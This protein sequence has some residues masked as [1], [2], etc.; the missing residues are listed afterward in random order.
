M[1]RAAILFA[2]GL[3]GTFFPFYTVVLERVRIPGVLQRIAVVYLC[4]AFA[5]LYLKPKARAG[6]A[7]ALLAVYWALMKL[8]PVPDFGAGDLSPQGNF[9][10]W[11]DHQLL[12]AHTWRYAPGPGDPEGILSTLPAIVSALFGIFCGDLLRGALP[13]GAKLRRMLG[14][15][16][17]GAAAGLL[18]AP[19]FPLNKNLWSPTYVLFTTGLALFCLAATFWLVDLRG[20]AWASRLAGRGP[21]RSSAATRSSP[22]SAAA[23]WPRRCWWSSAGRRRARRSP[24]R[25]GSTSTA[26]PPSCPTT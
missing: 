23:S 5:Y 8:A 22:S 16:A 2:L 10:F 11:L 6:L 3:F 1:K 24:S 26:S 9:A 19:F 13:D 18:L 15:G 12:G 17:A 25:A 21:S 14:W 7:F 20:R 4:A